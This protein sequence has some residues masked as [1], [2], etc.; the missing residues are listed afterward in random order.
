MLHTTSTFPHTRLA[1]PPPEEDFRGESAFRVEKRWF[2]GFAV[3][4]EREPKAV[5]DA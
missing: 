4:D 1:L 2:S 5:F 3:E